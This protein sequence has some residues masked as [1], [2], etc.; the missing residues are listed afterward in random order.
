MRPI[1]YQFMVLNEITQIPWFNPL[2][3]TYLLYSILFLKPLISPIKYI[4]QRRRSDCLIKLEYVILNTE[5][6]TNWDH[7]SSFLK[8]GKM[9]YQDDNNFKIQWVCSCF[10]NHYIRYDTE[11]SWVC[12]NRST[13]FFLFKKKKK[14]SKKE[15][16]I[17]VSELCHLMS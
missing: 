5:K 3:L 2:C 14:V 13:Y 4:L 7:N 6:K 15:N 16:D 17:W 8:I 9:N 12:I 1:K 11:Y 10:R